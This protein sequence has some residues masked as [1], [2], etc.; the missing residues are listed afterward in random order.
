MVAAKGLRERVGGKRLAGETGGKIGGNKK[1]I[2]R[3][4]LARQGPV[5]LGQPDRN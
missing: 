3:V 4:F 2:Y 5:G 1:K